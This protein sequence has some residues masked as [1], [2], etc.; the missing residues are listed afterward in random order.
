MAKYADVTLKD[1]IWEHVRRGELSYLDVGV[2]CA[3]LRNCC[4]ETG[5]WSGN[6][7][8][9]ASAAPK[10]NPSTRRNIQKSLVDLRA[11]GFIRIFNKINGSNKPYEVLIHNYVPAAGIN[12]GKRLDACASS[13]WKHPKFV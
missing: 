7:G 1:G 13:D 10:V 5:R 12:A 3:L 4:R 11:N 6:A 8:E 9:L 2:F